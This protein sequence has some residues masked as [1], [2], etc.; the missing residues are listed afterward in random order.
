[1]KNY[2]KR[3]YVFIIICITI[4]VVCISFSNKKSMK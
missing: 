3:I 2:K 1:M 4:L